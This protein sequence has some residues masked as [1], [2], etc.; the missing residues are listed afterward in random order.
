MPEWDPNDAEAPTKHFLMGLIALDQR[1][2][3]YEFRIAE[4][5]TRIGLRPHHADEVRYD[6]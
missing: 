4:V 6:F 2:K 1:L 5:E 3:D